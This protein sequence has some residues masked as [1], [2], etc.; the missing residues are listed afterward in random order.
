MPVNEPFLK[1]LIAR[2]V[3]IPAPIRPH[4]VEHRIDVCDRSYVPRYVKVIIDSR[5]DTYDLS[6]R[7]QSLTT[8]QDIA[9]DHYITRLVSTW[10]GVTNVSVHRYGPPAN[11]PSPPEPEPNNWFYLSMALRVTATVYAALSLI[12]GLY[13]LA[14]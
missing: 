12:Y 3:A 1:E 14:K 5:H 6:A 11:P 2:N 8:L 13:Q 10:P 7:V 4:L 9:D